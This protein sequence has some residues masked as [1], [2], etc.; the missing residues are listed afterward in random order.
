MLR[1][2]EMKSYNLVSGIVTGCEKLGAIRGLVFCSIFIMVGNTEL[3]S[4]T[5][6][7]LLFLIVMEF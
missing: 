2:S 4:E 5:I 3:I 7:V 6:L 1:L